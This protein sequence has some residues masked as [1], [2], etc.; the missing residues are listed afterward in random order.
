M[1]LITIPGQVASMAQSPAPRE[2][3][4]GPGS[5]LDGFVNQ[6]QPLQVHWF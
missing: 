5:V 3:S 2:D 6:K 1:I 4:A